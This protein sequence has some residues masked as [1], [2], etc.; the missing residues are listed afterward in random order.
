MIDCSTSMLTWEYR[1]GTE[2]RSSSSS[3]QKER[4]II[5]D[6]GKY[7]KEETYTSWM[8]EI[9]V[10]GEIQVMNLSKKC[11]DI[12][13]K[14]VPQIHSTVDAQEANWKLRNANRKCNLWTYRNHVEKPSQPRFSFGK[15][16]VPKACL[17]CIFGSSPYLGSPY[18]PH[19][20]SPI[21][22]TVLNPAF[23]AEFTTLSRSSA[24][25]PAPATISPPSNGPSS[26]PSHGSPAWMSG[27]QFPWVKRTIM[28]HLSTS[29]LFFA[30][31]AMQQL[32][33]WIMLI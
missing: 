8:R 7:K 14:R 19:T 6:H 26:S 10:T 32:K 20:V 29:S 11:R 9:K 12:P 2:I 15:N 22:V 25:R 31:F 17:Q 13:R 16:L 24:P 30:P 28:Q 27:L 3:W 5:Q 23:I 33:R 1:L 18:S 21:L 4:S